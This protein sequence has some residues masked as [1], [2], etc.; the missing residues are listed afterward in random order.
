[1]VLKFPGGVPELSHTLF[2]VR[3]HARFTWR[4]P[5]GPGPLRGQ[6]QVG[7]A[8]SRL[9]R[10]FV[11]GYPH[12]GCSALRSPL[13]P[14]LQP[15]PAQTIPMI[16]DIAVESDEIRLLGQPPGGGTA[17]L[18]LVLAAIMACAF[19]GLVTLA[20]AQGAWL[21]LAVAVIPALFAWLCWYAGSKRTYHELVVDAQA[22]M[23]TLNTFQRGQL[24][25]Q[26]S[27]PFADIAGVFTEGDN[28][29]DNLPDS[30]ETLVIRLRNGGRR[31]ALLCADPIAPRARDL[32]HA[33]MDQEPAPQVTG[34]KSFGRRV[35]FEARQCSA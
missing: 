20:L 29:E 5:E 10:Y 33:A 17:A 25:S 23:V 22:R 24:A 2:C 7:L 31:L 34:L 28:S 12:S 13:K 26:R 3:H 19:A 16:R 30:S 9:Q 27:V 8:G 4:T 6:M 11:T 14:A 35:A 18:L 32:I 15:F 21:F 1:M